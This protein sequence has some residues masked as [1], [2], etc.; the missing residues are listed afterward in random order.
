MKALKRVLTFAPQ[1]WDGVAPPLNVEVTQGTEEEFGWVYAPPT[2]T[3][4]LEI[5]DQAVV[6]AVEDLGEVRVNRCIFQSPAD[7][8]VRVVVTDFISGF[9][10]RAEGNEDVVELVQQ[11]LST[12]EFT[13]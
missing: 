10:E 1:G 9:P 6:K 13:Q 11:V 4:S 7:G 8:S 2:S 5:G 12:F 3:E